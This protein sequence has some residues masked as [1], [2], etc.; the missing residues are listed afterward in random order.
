VVSVD[1]DA[2]R[3]LVAEAFPTAAPHWSPD[4]SAVVYT[5]PTD[6]GS[7]A[8]VYVLDRRTSDKTKLPDSAGFWKVNWSPN[9]KFLAAVT[10]D[11]HRIAMFDRLSQRWTEICKGAVLGPAVWSADSG[12]IYFQDILELDEPVHRVSIVNKKFE[13][14]FD[15]GAT[16]KGVQRCGF[17][18]M[19][20][21]GALVLRLTRGDHDVY[22]LDLDLP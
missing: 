5:V 22:A 10:E 9:G 1:G 15:C 2:P 11:N 14:V 19:T 6:A 20:P 7:A 12:Y 8:G 4:G 13:R 21:D 16:L 18:E 3:E 17:E